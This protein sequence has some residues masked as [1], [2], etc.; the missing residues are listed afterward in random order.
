M[1][2]IPH[3][4]QHSDI[5]GHRIPNSAALSTLVELV[6]KYKRNRNINDFKTTKVIPEISNILFIYLFIVIE[7]AI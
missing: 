2:N 4:H 3:L 1:K 6:T 5:L 7:V